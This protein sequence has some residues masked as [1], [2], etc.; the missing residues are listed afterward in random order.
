M[1]Q[2]RVTVFSATAHRN[3]G[4]GTPPD[5]HLPSDDHWRIWVLHRQKRRDALHTQNLLEERAQQGQRPDDVL[6]SAALVIDGGV[7][8]FDARVRLQLGVLG[9]V[10]KH[11]RARGGGRVGPGHEHGAGISLQAPVTH[12]AVLLL[13]LVDELVQDGDRRALAPLG[14][15]EHVVHGLVQLHVLHPAAVQVG[16]DQGDLVVGQEAADHAANGHR[17][18]DRA[19]VMA[20]VRVSVRDAVEVLAKADERDGVL[21]PQ[22]QH[23]TDVH[24]LPALALGLEHVHELLGDLVDAW[25]VR[26]NGRVG[27]RGGH[28]PPLHAPVGLLRGEEARR[29]HVHD[30]PSPRSA[31]DHLGPLPEQGLDVLPVRQEQLPLAAHVVLAGA[32]PLSPLSRHLVH[33]LEAVDDFR[34]AQE[35][36][37]AR[38][39][40]ELAAEGPA[41]EGSPEADCGHQ[42]DSEHQCLC[43]HRARV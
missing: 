16:A 8:H 14:L 9:E 17:G 39:H 23:F 29:R 31:L 25:H 24:G 3:C 19:H 18:H 42:G 33:L 20:G 13:V 40:A 10:V 30:L 35:P 43:Q 22:V 28:Q 34:V 15:L 21:G 5:T 6:E 1:V 4:K 27:E 26:C 37:P 38:N 36:T 11:P 32:V 41:G 2:A 7:L 12:D